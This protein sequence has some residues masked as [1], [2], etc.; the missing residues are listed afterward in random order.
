M[1]T[2]VGDT[3]FPIVFT[4]SLT[5]NDLQITATSQNPQCISKIGLILGE[6]RPV[7]STI[8]VDL[9]AGATWADSID[10]TACAGEKIPTTVHNSRKYSIQGTTEIRGRQ[11]LAIIRSERIQLSG[12]GSQDQHQIHLQGEGTATTQL[13]IDA[14]TGLLITAE[15]NQQLHVAITA[16]GRVQSFVQT[17]HQVI[18]L[19]R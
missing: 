16:S 7:I 10:T 8:P 4:G 3:H 13:N 18:D 19:I 12:D 17:T 15:S 9:K 6:V 1:T 11:T 14:E 2:P 5:G